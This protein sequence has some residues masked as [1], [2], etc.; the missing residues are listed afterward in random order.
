VE[1]ILPCVPSAREFDSRNVGAGETSAVSVNL[2]RGNNSAE[3]AEVQPELERR[4]AHLRTEERQILIPI[5]SNW[6]CS[7]MTK[8]QQCL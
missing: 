4:L 3:L 2:I 8:S 1:D 6:T 7:A 5:M